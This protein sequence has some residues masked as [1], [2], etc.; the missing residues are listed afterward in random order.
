MSDEDL[1]YRAE[2]VARRHGFR[3]VHCRACEGRGFTLVPDA[4]D[5]GEAQ[6]ELCPACE[7]ERRWKRE[8]AG[9]WYSDAELVARFDAPPSP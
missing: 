6:P 7:G 9:T 5:P 4:R 8:G 2:S 1:A 3:P